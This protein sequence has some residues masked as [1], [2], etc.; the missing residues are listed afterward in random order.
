MT[1]CML[2]NSQIRS[3]RKRAPVERE[4]ELHNFVEPRKKIPRICTESK[5]YKCIASWFFLELCTDHKGVFGKSYKCIAGFSE[6]CIQTSLNSVTQITSF[7][8]V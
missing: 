3:V 2:T 4:E 8:L 1:E 6:N 5:S 7:L